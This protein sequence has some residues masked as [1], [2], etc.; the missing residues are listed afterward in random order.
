MRPPAA[1]GTARA[2]ATGRPTHLSIGAA[3]RALSN[4]QPHRNRCGRRRAPTAA[5]A[6]G[7]VR[8]RDPPRRRLRKR[9]AP[10]A[11]AGYDRQGCRS[12]AREGHNI[13][14]KWRRL[15]SSASPNSPLRHLCIRNDDLGELRLHRR[16]VHDGR[17]DSEA[18][19]LGHCDL[20][21]RKF[22]VGSSDRK[23]A[24]LLKGSVLDPGRLPPCRLDGVFGFLV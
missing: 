8:G 14:Q 7:A 6:K 1:T 15:F 10:L 5:A 4:R 3:L 13:T 23:Q 9:R 24:E 17:A 2:A 21:G 20:K 22:N 12:W 19:L 11:A 16:Q 18:F